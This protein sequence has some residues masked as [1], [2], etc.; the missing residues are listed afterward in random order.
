[1]RDLLWVGLPYL[2]IA[3]FAVGHVW[4]YRRDRFDWTDEWMQL[5]K[6]RKARWGIVLFH[7]GTFAVIAGHVLGILVPPRLTAYV[8]IGEAQYRVL[9]VLLGGLFGVCVLVGLGG[10]L[11][12]RT[13]V[14]QIVANTTW[15]DRVTLGLI[16]VVVVLGMVATLGV[17]LFGGG[18]DYRSTVAVWFRSIL[19]LSPRPELVASAPLIYQVHAVAAWLLVMIWPFS[20]LVHAWYFPFYFRRRVLELRHSLALRRA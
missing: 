18:Y 16:A 19:L 7:A 1:M 8:W 11:W 15:V 14:A 10:L 9:A 13:M 12:R 20:R 3:V 4:R 5:L 2:A 6:P 17:N